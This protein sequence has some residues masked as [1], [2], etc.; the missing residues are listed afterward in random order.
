M[1]NILVTGG[2]GY[3]GSH[4]AKAL[5]AS[6]YT[7]VVYDNLSNGHR[8]FVRWG[9]LVEADIL[10]GA[11]L[12]SAMQRYRPAAVMH[13]AGRIEAGASV[14][15]PDLFYRTNVLGTLAVLEAMRE[16]DVPTLVFSS[17]A[18]VYGAPA[19]SP[20]PESAAIAPINPYGAGKAASERMIS[21]FGSA[22]GTRW[23]AL[24]YFNASGADPDGE[25]GEWHDP[26]THLIPRLLAA[27]AGSDPEFRVN[28]ADYA[29][30]DGTCVRD[31]IHVSDLARAH[32]RAIAFL[33][34]R[35]GTHV[36]NLGTGTG[37]SVRA[38]ISTA[39]AVTGRTIKVV[40]GPR[41]AGDATSLVADVRK[42][43]QELGWTA[44]VTA[45]ADHVRDAWRWHQRFVR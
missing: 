34:D 9:P 7:P 20:I 14:I 19:R 36:F 11:A 45:V 12:A 16:H 31:Y 32:V 29:T 4:A 38:M 17:T 24:R 26:E 35:S 2:A 40:E 22:F 15:R 43:A 44:Q 30:P 10:D 37:T 6:G 42:A 18:A 39:E 28:G 23:V 13:F 27:A 25:T 8:E 33:E 5:A 21:D 1:N 3:V 41:R